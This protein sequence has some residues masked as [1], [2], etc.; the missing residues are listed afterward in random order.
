VLVI[1]AGKLGQFI[2]F[3]VQ[4]IS[5]SRLFF[6]AELAT[7]LFSF[8]LQLVGPLD[9]DLILGHISLSHRLIGQLEII[10]VCIVALDVF[11]CGLAAECRAYIAASSWG[12][13]GRRGRCFFGRL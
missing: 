9:H 2:G 7:Q 12:R 8:A 4:I 3:S 10:D 6:R 11:V 13:L 1:L 5:K